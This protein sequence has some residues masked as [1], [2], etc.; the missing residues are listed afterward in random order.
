M[1]RHVA[2]NHI[3]NI[4]RDDA[5]RFFISYFVLCSFLFLI[6]EHDCALSILMFQVTE[7]LVLTIFCWNKSTCQNACPYLHFSQSVSFA[8]SAAK[9]V[10][11]AIIPVCLMMSKHI[12]CRFEF[13]GMGTR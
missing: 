1:S 5:F 7:T 12:A 13:V 11:I 3:I 2:M 9:Y 8:H 10:F 4:V 6:E